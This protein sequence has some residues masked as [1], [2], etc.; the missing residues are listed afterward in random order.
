MLPPK[1][2]LILG[3]GASQPYGFPVASE[4]RN[5]IL[6]GSDTATANFERSMGFALPGTYGDWIL[7]V[8]AP[9]FGIPGIK[10]FQ[11][12]FGLA[13]GIGI[14]RFI[15][16]NPD[17]EKLG[18]EFIAAILLKCEK[19]AS[20]NGDWYPALFGELVDSGSYLNPVLSVITFNYDRSFERFVYQS[21]MGLN[22]DDDAESKAF[23][24]R[25][26]ITHVY[27]SLG[28][29]FDN[30][31]THASAVPFGGCD[32][33]KIKRSA[34]SI[35]LMRPKTDRRQ[36]ERIKSYI[37]DAERII[38]LGF[39]FD[40]MNLDA[41]GINGDPGSG[42][43]IHASCFG[44]SARR[45]ISAERRIV[46]TIKWGDPSYNVADFLHYSE[47]LA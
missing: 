10:D 19:D 34:D 8:L 23:L 44:L 31:V 38:F 20:V 26:R 40:E 5:L 11:R 22:N 15:A 43:T 25:I 13:Q 2:L 33:A 18:K 16:E 4:L 3:A 1:T 41:L 37:D 42:K 39:G 36:I 17:E 30:P 29:L 27:G 35:N 7:D 6:G 21:S 28:P 14:D 45:K 9:T 12:R 47:A 32:K 24:K 46:R